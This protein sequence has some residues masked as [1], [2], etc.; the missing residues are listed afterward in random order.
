[1]IDGAIH[2]LLFWASD[3][4]VAYDDNRDQVYNL[5]YKDAFAS[6]FGLF[7]SALSMFG[8]E[9]VSTELDEL[10]SLRLEKDERVH[11]EWRKTDGAKDWVE[12][13]DGELVEVKNLHW[14]RLQGRKWKS[15]YEPSDDHPH[16]PH[17]E[18]GP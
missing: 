15:C 17:E 7:G 13:E 18:S 3:T 2:T 16:P 6:F 1:L 12:M 14:E 10:K 5:R 11:S 8:L 9:R 4:T